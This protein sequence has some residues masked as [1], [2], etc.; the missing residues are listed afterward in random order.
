M[1][2][3]AAAIVAVNFAERSVVFPARETARWAG[4]RA[5]TAF[6]SLNKTNANIAL[7]SVKLSGTLAFSS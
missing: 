1:S 4:A 6:P 3:R 7:A 5:S 2:T